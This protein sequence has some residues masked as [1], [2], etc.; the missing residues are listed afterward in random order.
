MW[1]VSSLHSHLPVHMQAFLDSQIAAGRLHIHNKSSTD[2]FVRFI[3]LL[4]HAPPNAPGLKT[5]SIAFPLPSPAAAAILS[6]CIRKHSTLSSLSLHL[7]PSVVPNAH[8]APPV[9]SSLSCLP[10][11]T[12]LTLSFA[13]PTSPSV[14]DTAATITA[15]H[16]AL[17][18]LP[19][20]RSVR[21]S[22][23][24]I[25][26]TPPHAHTASASPTG[27]PTAATPPG[28]PHRQSPI[29]RTDLQSLSLDPV[30]AALSTRTALEHLTLSTLLGERDIPLPCS[31]LA[32]E[33]AALSALDITL[34]E[35]SIV[36]DPPADC[37]YWRLRDAVVISPL[38]SLTRLH[39][40]LMSNKVNSSFVK[41]LF[42]SV[43]C[44]PALRSVQVCLR[45]VPAESV[46]DL[47]TLLANLTRLA[48]LRFILRVTAPF[49]ARSMHAAA[50]GLAQLSSLT[51]LSF[52]LGETAPARGE[53]W[54]EDDWHGG[55]ALAPLAGLTQLRSL[56]CSFGAAWSPAAA[57]VCAT[58]R[59]QL[60]L[61]PL[62]R[63][64]ALSLTMCEVDVP[65]AD[66]TAVLSQLGYLI[67]L[68]VGRLQCA[69]VPH[70][71]ELLRHHTAL[72][73]MKLWLT[74]VNAAVVRC[75]GEY[76]RR[77]PHIEH[78][79]V[80]SCRPGAPPGDGTTSSEAEADWVDALDQLPL[81]AKYVFKCPCADLPDE[82]LKR[83]RTQLLRRGAVSSGTLANLR[84]KRGE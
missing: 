7:P 37:P 68:H 82:D 52:A 57:Q 67:Q 81:T 75:I 13:H 61:W 17:S 14:S 38:P 63:L 10:Q 39:F 6:E 65:C 23:L 77:Q 1:L 80:S 26:C 46:Q 83:V 40:T 58:W 34:E 62:V 30:V 84:I 32:G 31:R 25:S 55:A 44:H 16:A 9:L 69:C 53:P 78:V 54:V 71:A 73:R 11:L 21:L 12:S 79:H 36:I 74:P 27:S 35:E 50:A 5:L 49:P 29:H 42:R 19:G 43:A 48:S 2:D 4:S 72:R 15:L 59:Q 28:G 3:F 41:S 45:S 22:N 47:E 51:H 64:R 70:L 66:A 20:L 24:R 56:L 18:N 76:V 60:H 8:V 33:F